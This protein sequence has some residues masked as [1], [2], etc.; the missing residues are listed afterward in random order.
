MSNQIDIT[1]GARVRNLN[2]VI[3]GTTGVLSSVPYG[4]ANGV[5]TLDSSGKIPVSQLPNSVME[6]KG[7]WNVTTNTPYLVNGVG[8]AGDVYMVTGA[9]VGGTLHDFGSGNILFY[10][11]DQAIYDGSAWQR[12]NGSTGTVTS[13]AASI[14][15]N[16]I[17]ITGSPITTAGTLAFAFA[18]TNLQYIN[19]AGNLTTFPSLT[20]YVPY[21]GATNDLNLGTH[22]LYANNLFDGF[23]NVAASGTQIVLTI[24]STPSYTITGSGGQTIKLPDATTLPN[25]AIFSFN[26]NQSSG[27]ITI[28][29]NSNTLVVSVPSGGFAEVVLLD[30]S[31]AAGS[32]DRHFKAPSNVSWSTNTLDYAGSITSATWNG[33]VV[34]I[35]RGGTGSSTQNFVDLTTTQTIGGVKTFNNGLNL[36]AGYYPVPIAGDTGLAS[37]GSGLSILLKSG[38]NVYTNNLQ[39]S[40]A[41][42]DYTFPNAS[43][44][45]ALTSN[46]SSYVPYTGA[47]ASVDLGIWDLDAAN[48]FSNG[49]GVYIKKNVSGIANAV[50]YVALSS[51]TY[52][53]NVAES[54]SGSFAKSFSFDFSGL[55]NNTTRT[56][57]LPDASG[58][59]ALLENSQTFTGY[60][61]FDNSVNIKGQLYLG[62]TSYGG[63][64]SYIQGSVFST[65][66]NTT[67]TEFPDVNSIKYYVG[68]GVSGYKNFVFDVSN[69]TLNATRTYTLP[70]ATGTLA[71]T[72]QIPSLTGYVP[73]TGATQSVNLGAFDLT[74][75][76]VKIG[77]GAGSLTSNTIVG[78][79]SLGLN[80]T[81]YEN[82][83]VGNGAMYSNTTGYDNVAVGYA[84]LTLNTSGTY[85]T[86]VGSRSL[87]SN[88][89]G[90]N[91]TA[92]GNLSL[93][94]NTTGQS[95]VAVGGSALGVNT[96]GQ[97]NVGVGRSA[98]N[99]NTTGNYNTALGGQAL[100]NVTTGSQNLAIGY[101][102]GGGITTGS[103]NTIIGSVTGLSS[104]LANNV[105]LAD[106]AGTIR[107]QWDG[108]D[109]RTTG[110]LRP[111]GGILDDG[112]WIALKQVGSSAST[113]GYFT[114]NT[115]AVGS[116][117][118]L[119]MSLGAGVNSTFTFNNATNYTY[120]FPSTSGTVA[121]TS[122]IPSNIITGTGTRAIYYIPVFSGSANTIENSIIQQVS[123]N[124]GIGVSPSFK[125]D[126]NGTGRF[127]GVL[128]LG[129]TLSNGTY[130]YTL[131]SATGTL[132]LTSDISGYLPL[133]GGTLTGQLY[134]NP[135]NTATV[136]LDVA[137]NTTRFRSDN[138]EGYKRQL[139]ITM[140]SGTLV[141]MTASGY[142]GTYGTDLA[143][144]TSSASG[145]NGSPAM[146][147][148]GGNNI[149]IGTGSPSYTLDVSGTGRFTSA[150][151]VGTAP[152]GAFKVSIQGD[153]SG[154]ALRLRNTTTRYRSDFG[155][156][157]S[158]TLGINCYDDTGSTYM[159]IKIEGSSIQ[160]LQGNVGIGTSSPANLLQVVN[161][162]NQN[163]A[164]G[165]IQAY[166]SGSVSS[167]NSGLTVKNYCGT[168]QFM[169]WESYGI[170]LG[171]RI[172]TNSGQGNVVFTYGNDVEGMRITSGGNLQVNGTIIA[173]NS[174]GNI[175]VTGSTDGGVFT[176]GANTMF[177]SDWNSATKGLYVNLITGATTISQL[178]SGTVTAT[179]G[180]L[181]A[182]SDMNLKI[183]DGF[184][185]NALEKIMNLKP[186]YFHW[187]EE[188]G[189]PTDLRQLG[190]YAQEVNQA[191]GEEVANTPKNEN[192][193][194][195]IYD[196]ALIAM[197]TKG[198][199]EQ[200]SQI[201]ELK[202]QVQTLL[203]K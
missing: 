129:S 121:L 137:S 179:S 57:I 3:T 18:G 194:W 127:T 183:E 23:T 68:Q 191:L 97:Y 119:I 24:A 51:S 85:N 16:S 96:T 74:V 173:L 12:A 132:A 116:T 167:A 122:D 27:A 140:G 82:T 95:N 130:T 190:F 49:L 192:D 70:D 83:A 102:A 65:S 25:G 22:N 60:K 2:G 58:T 9:A 47:T 163:D 111:A 52:K 36:R 92:I 31:I 29:N 67:T 105:I 187:K 155:V 32:W 87:F 177:F 125:L 66:G 106:G 30:N 200:Q 42:N 175:K 5:A 21:T 139:A 193:K 117:E 79:G 196:R 145:V 40:N 144:Y 71:L 138:L 104:T 131:P 69:I 61:T 62:G 141:Q 76:G 48:L 50:G 11:G 26:N 153:D 72:S 195:G 90:N 6:Y 93:N 154:Q 59:I 1:G 124:I 142:G 188:S 185:N 172:V 45:I 91:N 158:G 113:T 86:S 77:L 126:V 13:V 84:S 39:F 64:V 75:N 128:T 43:G 100:A 15:G 98:S 110:R 17:G 8:N 169:Q 184:I 148:T 109:T 147:I 170:R 115:S 123:S 178:G 161:S 14:T 54:S 28:N 53:L 202:A 20:G 156:A 35:N 160:L 99:A 146:Y 186:R 157:N 37:S 19:G 120:T 199:Q 189:L 44:T 114:L 107:F 176:G 112:G 33:N 80:T 81:G 159:P 38:A 197:L 135:T 63:C 174:G 108:T 171:S 151:S 201:E 150:L 73:Y 41:S 56:Y 34:A 165:N 133:T 78:A 149:G 164:I 55:T 143:F 101:N 94:L 152:I 89:T 103:Q 182:I 180:T 7:T 166:Y 134:I 181:S 162:N 46:L 203:N 4:G 168:S 88:T 118:S 10:N 198:M 136:G